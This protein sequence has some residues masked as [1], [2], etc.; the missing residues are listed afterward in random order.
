LLASNGAAK[1]LVEVE[2]VEEYVR[3]VFLLTSLVSEVRR[4]ETTDCATSAAST[5]SR[6]MV[7]GG[8]HPV[9]EETSDSSDEDEALSSSSPSPSCPH[10]RDTPPHRSTT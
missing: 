4:V 3:F 2:V 1:L 8:A 10:R 6:L 9:S 7:V 5:F